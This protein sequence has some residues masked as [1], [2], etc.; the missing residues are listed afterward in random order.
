MHTTTQS[1]SQMLPV[2]TRVPHEAKATAKPDRTCRNQNFIIHLPEGAFIPGSLAARPSENLIIDRA[3]KTLHWSAVDVIYNAYAKV[4]YTMKG[5]YGKIVPACED[6]KK[7][8]KSLLI[9]Y[10]THKTDFLKFLE[11]ANKHFRL[12]HRNITPCLGICRLEDPKL[13]LLLMPHAGHPLH[14]E[15]DHLGPPLPWQRILHI[16][17][18][19]V[20]GL[21]YIHT[22]KIVHADIS[23]SNILLTHDDHTSIC[24][25]GSALQTGQKNPNLIIHADCTAYSIFGKT[26]NRPLSLADLGLAPEL[27]YGESATPKSD[28]YGWGT[29]TLM[30]LRCD[31]NWLSWTNNPYCQFR[32]DCPHWC[33]HMDGK[34]NLTCNIRSSISHPDTLNIRLADNIK[35]GALEKEPVLNLQS[36]AERSL[37]INPEDRPPSA[38]YLCDLIKQECLPPP[39]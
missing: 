7:K 11:E 32:F 23:A 39:L 15:L 14:T 30:M 37:Q 5:S 3:I 27:F 38:Q 22:N 1:S 20:E 4:P 8:S 13:I 36:A 24:D 25:F 10:N 18:Q 28:L 9:K 19:V 21:A 17:S 29:I 35:P 34:H 2:T 33:E 26:I 16:S 6:W 31:D 12:D